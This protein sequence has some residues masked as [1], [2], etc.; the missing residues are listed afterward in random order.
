MPQD[1]VHRRPGQL[2]IDPPFPDHRRGG[3]MA[4]NFAPGRYARAYPASW[5]FWMLL[6][7]MITMAA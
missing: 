4:D 1:S 6:A 7:H 5:L 2:A 3:L